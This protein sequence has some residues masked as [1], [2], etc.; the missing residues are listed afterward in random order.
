M[1]YFMRASG[2]WAVENAGAFPPRLVAPGRSWGRRTGGRTT[3]KWKAG[4]SS[5]LL[6]PRAVVLVRGVNRPVVPGTGSKVARERCAVGGP[7]SR[8]DECGRSQGEA[9]GTGSGARTPRPPESSTVA[10]CRVQSLASGRS[11]V[12]PRGRPGGDWR[13]PRGG[14]S[15]RD[16]GERV[17]DHRR[18]ACSRP[19]SPAERG[20]G[21][22]KR[23]LSLLPKA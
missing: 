4:G 10:G 18:A 12:C 16:N 7:E 20:D 14:C 11:L 9:R 13:S 17:R 22:K 19:P 1:T 21:G 5:S 2:E 3:W 8:N 23:T 15:G 6:P